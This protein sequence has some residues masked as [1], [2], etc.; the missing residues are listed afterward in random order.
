MT[1]P[2]LICGGGIGGLSTAIALA[3]AGMP[4]KLLERA[5]T[6]SEAGAG[7]ELGPNAMRHLSEWG[8]DPLIS[9]FAGEPEGMRVFDGMTGQH[10]T[11]APL[12][13]FVRQRY[14]APYLVIHRKHLQH[15]LLETAAQFNDLEIETGFTL[16]GYE[17]RA[18][19]VYVESK[20]GASS[21]GRALIGADGLWSSV[22]AGFT[23]AIPQT[24]GVTAWRALL[25]AE[26]APETVNTPF[27]G[28]WLGPHGHVVHYPLDGGAAICI[29]AMIEETFNFDGWA[30]PGATDDLLAYFG[31][32]DDKVTGLLEL[33]GQWHKWTVM[34]MEPLDHWGS[35]PVS[36]VGDA[37][38]P[39]EPFMAQ[40]GATAIEDAAAI[41]AAFAAAPDNLESAMRAYESS[42]HRR[43][44]RIQKASHQ[45]GRIYHLSGALRWARDRML[46][47]L[48]PHSLV[49]RYDWLYEN[50]T[51]TA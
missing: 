7:I 43:A 30:S 41:A 12:G 45:R 4:V 50:P 46:R 3:R 47:S 38:H 33:P 49:T 2:I 51:P 34:R 5:T 14:G 28:I 31:S 24:S 39:I 26:E 37:A 1:D 10:L 18:D 36:L 15:C 16:T 27:V 48:N 13:S 21:S 11:T 29:V 8:L 6:F 35:G 23:D 19:R 44:T 17:T 32:W 20:S 25:P 9:V 42:R 40:G 22:R